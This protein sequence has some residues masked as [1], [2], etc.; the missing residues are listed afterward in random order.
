MCQVYSG[1]RCIRVSGVFRCQVYSGARCIRVSGVFRCQV[2]P[3]VRCIQVSGVV[4]S[5]ATML[6]TPTTTHNMHAG[7]RNSTPR[8]QTLGRH[9][10]DIT[11]RLANS[12]GSWGSEIRVTSECVVPC[13]Y[14]VCSGLPLPPPGVPQRSLCSPMCPCPTVIIV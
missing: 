4:L 11:A 10:A 3:G 12:A 14:G 9:L 7:T 2:Y 1:A 13:L 5:A 6:H 8:K